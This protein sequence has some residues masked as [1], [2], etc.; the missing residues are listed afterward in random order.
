MLALQNGNMDPGQMPYLY[1]TISRHPQHERRM[2]YGEDCQ[3]PYKNIE[4]PS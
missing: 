4:K 1:T 3:G 2:G